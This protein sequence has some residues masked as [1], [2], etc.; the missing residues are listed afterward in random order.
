MAHHGGEGGGVRGA[1]TGF[2]SAAGGN[3]GVSLIGAG[4]NDVTDFGN[5]TG[6]S[7][8]CFAGF[9]GAGSDIDSFQPTSPPPTIA[10]MRPSRLTLRPKSFMSV[11]NPTLRFRRLR[12]SAILPFGQSV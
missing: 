4:F 12:R 7:F 9:S 11:V 3:C 5:I 6:P 1:S 8:A 10:T 2:A